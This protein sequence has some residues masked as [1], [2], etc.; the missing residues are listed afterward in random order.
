MNRKRSGIILLSLILA[1][2][3]FGLTGCEEDNGTLE[4]DDDIELAEQTYTAALFF[5]NEEYVTIGDESL[6]KYFVYEREFTAMPGEAYFE[7]VEMLRTPPEE[8]Y[9][10]SITDKIKFNDIYMAGDTVYVNLNK[11]GLSGGSTEEAYLIGQVVNTLINT[12]TEVQ[13]VQFLIDGE[14]SESL[15]GHIDAASPFTREAF[16]E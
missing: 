13:Q 6:K 12:F 15:M 14:V 4:P 3:M 7:A 16:E 8:G 9:S 10:T 1:L 2:S 5:S 11:N